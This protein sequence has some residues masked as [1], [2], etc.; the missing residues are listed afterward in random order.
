MRM[1][2]GEER[3]GPR[4]GMRMCSAQNYGTESFTLNTYTI[5]IAYALTLNTKLI[6]FVLAIYK[7][8][9]FKYI[10]F[11]R[12]KYA[13]ILSGIGISPENWSPD[14]RIR[15]D[16]TYNTGEIWDYI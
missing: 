9:T 3:A 15:S 2:F 14:Y 4:D 5:R 6:D 11:A 10:F 12:L 1:G 8:I 7:Y 16:E 13:T